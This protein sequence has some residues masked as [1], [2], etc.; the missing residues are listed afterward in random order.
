MATARKPKSP[1][2]RSPRLSKALDVL[3]LGH[4]APLPP[5][6]AAAAAEAIVRHRPWLMGST[7][8]GIGIG[9][10]MVGGKPT[11]ELVLK[12]YVDRKLPVSKLANPAPRSVKLPGIA[13]AVE[14]DVE[15][16]G[17]IGLEAA[18]GGAPR[19]AAGDEIGLVGNE[20]ITGT[21]GC[22]V[23]KRDDPANLYLLSNAHVIANCGLAAEGARVTRTKPAP[24]GTAFASYS[25]CVGFTYSPEGYYNKADAAIARLDDPSGSSA[26]I[27][28]I[29]PVAGVAYDVTP[30]DRVRLFG[31]SSDYSEGFVKDIDFRFE[32]Q[33]P[34]AGGGIGRVGFRDQVLCSD[35]T[36]KGDSGALVLDA[37]GQ[38]VG[39]HFAGSLDGEQ[40]CSIFS[41]IGAVLAEL[42]IDIV[43]SA[44]DVPTLHATA[45]S[46]GASAAPTA[47]GIAARLAALAVSHSFNGG[48]SWQLVRDGLSVG[49]QIET[50]GGEPESAARVWG[51]W[52]ESILRWANHFEVPVELIVATI[53][54]ESGGKPGALRLEPGYVSDE[55]TPGKVSPGLMQTLIRTARDVLGNQTL[56]RGWLMVP[57]HSIQAGTAYIAHQAGKTK[58]DPPFV[59][60]AYNAGGV[61]ANAGAANRWRMRQYPI[62]SGEHADRFAKWFND[63]FRMFASRAE[64]PLMSFFSALRG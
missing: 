20:P 36:R 34:L 62:D 52:G 46:P 43:T 23:R 64:A 3:T 24:A 21:L 7:V 4:R 8:Q 38:A 19:Y 30:G 18:A 33:Y 6:L 50:T 28:E 15:E 49:G 44:A 11:G 32:M 25:Q 9:E 55:A 42:Q 5:K 29:G 47:P 22:M 26:N 31:A 14:I 12:V 37:A 40:P 2:A 54:T 58:L 51:T 59:A 10:R 17:R 56:D 27:P 48:V 16:I 41:P 63:C 39:L 60:C 1:G 61:Y 13:G 45:A 35:F 57:D 53:L